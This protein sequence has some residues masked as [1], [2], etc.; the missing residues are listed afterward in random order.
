MFEYT[1][2]INENIKFTMH[3]TTDRVNEWDYL[4]DGYFTQEERAE[5]CELV[6]NEKLEML[7]DVD[8]DPAALGM[9]AAYEIVTAGSNI[10]ELKPAV[11][12]SGDLH[13]H[14]STQLLG[15]GSFG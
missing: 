14:R 5:L 7:G 8:L 9:L 4:G 12:V 10:Y 6:R 11:F 13:W 15:V 1:V 2:D 3:T